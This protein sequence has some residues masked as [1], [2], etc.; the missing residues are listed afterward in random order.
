MLVKISTSILDLTDKIN[1]IFELNDTDTDYV[2]IDVMDGK[3]VSS[4]SFDKVSLVNEIGSICKKRLDIHLMVENP[5]DYLGKLDFSNVE[6]VTCHLELGDSLEKVIQFIRLKGCKV[7]VAISPYTDLNLLIPYLE[8][9]DMVLV[10]SVVP[11]RGGQQFLK[12]IYQRIRKL[13]EMIVNRKLEVLIS[14][15]GGV[16]DLVVKQLKY[17]DILVVGSYIVKSDDYEARIRLIRA[18]YRYGNKYE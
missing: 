10:M 4:V 9:I 5:L 14:V 18:N 2:H 7:G 16:N 1:G 17:V 15:D 13:W 11:G 12:F 8:K 3:F 6:F